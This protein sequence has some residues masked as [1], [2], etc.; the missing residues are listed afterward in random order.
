[1]IMQVIDGTDLILGRASSRIAKMLLQGEEVHLVNAEKM[2]RIGNPKDITERYKARRRI[3][4]KATPE[5]SPK[6]SNVPHFLVRRIVRGMLPWKKATGRAAYKRLRV[7]SGNPKN[8]EN[9]KS[10]DQ[11]KF[12]KR[13][14]YITI[15]Q[16]C[17]HL[18][19]SG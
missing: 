4:H 8:L 3:K 2:V 9:A 5:H 19:Y 17:K 7:Y 1:M 11:A 15:Y 6:W 10:L 18:G 16:L 12:T 14:R 13:A